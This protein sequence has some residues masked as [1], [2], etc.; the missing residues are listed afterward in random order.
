MNDPAFRRPLGHSLR[1]ARKAVVLIVGCWTLLHLGNILSC[2]DHL[3]YPEAS[4]RERAGNELGE[5]EWALRTYK[6]RTGQLPRTGDWPELVKARALEKEPRDPWGNPYVFSV[7]EDGQTEVSSLGAD[8]QP[9][10]DADDED[11]VRRFQLP[12]RSR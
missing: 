1:E 4:K 2:G 10:G 8:G 3:F 7:A 9:G 5:L 12:M 6:V 11:L